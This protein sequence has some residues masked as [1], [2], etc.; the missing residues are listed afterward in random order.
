MNDLTLAE[1]KVLQT[2]GTAYKEN[3]YVITEENGY[4]IVYD[5]DMDTVYEYT[6]IR[7]EYLPKDIYEQVSKGLYV[8][9]MKEVYGFLENYSS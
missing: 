2:E 8:E 5:Y 3:G 4:V 9:S 7:T 1:E 6:S